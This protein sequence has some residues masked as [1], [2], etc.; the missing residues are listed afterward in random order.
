VTDLSFL[1]DAS[2]NFAFA[3][4]LLEHL[5]HAQSARLLSQ[6]RRVLKPGGRFGVIQPNF[7]YCA[8]R[9][10]DDYTHVTVFSHISLSDFLEANGFSVIE[11]QGRFLPLTV[12]S[13]LPVRP[14]LVRLYLS[15]PIKPLAGQ[16]WI[17]ATP[18]NVG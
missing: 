15:S 13:R 1:P 11:C 5:T 18:K 16:M 14:F 6:L 4:N 8:S 7:R 10:F 17:L 3:S 2:V 12:K 9:Y